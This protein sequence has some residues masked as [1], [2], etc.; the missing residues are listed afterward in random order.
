MVVPDSLA[1][2]RPDIQGL[3]AIAVL[4]VVAFHAGLP[5]PGGFVGVDVF[6]V[7]SGYVIT[8]MLYRESQ[9]SGRINF[10]RFYWRRFK[11]LTPALALMIAVV[12]ALSAL[13][14]SPLGPQQN[15]A[16]TG[17]GAMLLAANVVI[18]RTTG[19]YFDAGADTNPL[20]N[21][22]S[23]SVEEQFYLVFPALLAFGWVLGRKS[24]SPTRTAITLV[25]TVALV[26]FTLALASAR[27]FTFYGSTSFLGFYSPITRAWEFAVGALLA[28]ALATAKRLPRWLPALSG[29]VGTALLVPSLWLIDSQTL[30]PSHWTLLPVLGTALLILSGTTAGRTSQFLSAP[31]LVRVG[32]W[33]YSIY[34][35]HWPFI[36]FA[37]LLFP[38]NSVALVVSALVSLAPAVMSYHW[39]EQPIRTYGHKIARKTGLLIAVTVVGPLLVGLGLGL[40]TTQVWYPRVEPVTAAAA[41]E[42]ANYPLGCHFGP[43]DG[44]QDPIPCTWN[45]SA[46]GPPVY[47]LGDSNAAH[48]VE[49]LITST[50]N[51]ER[52]LVVS[53]SSGCPLLDLSIRNPP[54]P[55]YERA[56]PARTARLLTWMHTQKH[57]TVVL[58]HTDLYWLSNDYPILS[59]DG[60]ETNDQAAKIRLM[61]ESLIRTI[62]RL[63]RSGH[64]VIF[65]QSVPKFF[66]DYSWDPTRC[67]LRQ[68]LTGC[69]QM[70]PL[71]AASERSRKVTRAVFQ[72]GRI[73][74]ARVLDL[75]NEICPDGICMTRI[76]DLPI[77]S[78]EEHIT[79][80]MSKVLSPV[81]TDLLRR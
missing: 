58:S 48:Y 15:A 66:G 71:V 25:S 34:L 4:M 77:Y 49:G 39:V 17:I 42:H 55:G 63:Q 67:T 51:L 26:S 41:K 30:F 80:A 19:D 10:R 59:L 8:A 38:H 33:S 22:W 62:A 21:T 9:E 50:R 35:W 64:D 56:C 18:D 76:N 12:L 44:Y 27:G 16:K 74:G 54:N 1:R 78:D 60:A 43:Q 28:L 40:V 79:V 61:Q 75:S 47:L 2:R 73:T 29:V 65:I 7:I 24:K 68:A 53:T 37:G 70:M 32:D 72:V 31:A 14:L 20:L 57:G 46:L 23:L 81:F 3:R 11:R 36:V 45:A 5:V 13:I 52:P 69:V 6:F